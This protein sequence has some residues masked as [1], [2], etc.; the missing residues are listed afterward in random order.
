MERQGQHNEARFAL[1][2]LPTA[3]AGKI[4]FLRNE[5]STAE[6]RIA[7]VNGHHACTVLAPITGTV[8]S[9]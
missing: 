5:L 4:Q 2:P 3:M 9:L 8:S 6:Q 1:D 7:E